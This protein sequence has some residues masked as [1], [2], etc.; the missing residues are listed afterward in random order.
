MQNQLIIENQNQQPTTISAEELQIGWQTNDQFDWSGKYVFK[1]DGSVDVYATHENG[2]KS[3][4]M[5]R[6]Q[7][8]VLSDNEK[9]KNTDTKNQLNEALRPATKNEFAIM[10]KKL[11]LHCGMQ[12]KG[13]AEVKSLMQDY[14]EDFG[15]YPKLLIEDACQQ[16]RIKPETNAWMPKSSDFIK[17]MHEKR[18]YLTK[19]LNRT[20]ILLREEIMNI[21]ED[22]KNGVK[23]LSELLKMAKQ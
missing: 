7:V 8:P 18:Y 13:E 6:K 19:L 4:D 14:W 17:I 2:I 23:T 15:D 11:T 20:K 1:Q 16:W 12:K 21:T 10:I 5:Q 9:M 22:R 3:I